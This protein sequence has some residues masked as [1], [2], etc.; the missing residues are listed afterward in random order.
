VNLLA[1]LAPVVAFLA[2]LLLMDSFKLVSVRSV[3]VAI[4]AGAVAALA[5]LVID[6]LALDR[7][8]LS[9]TVVSRYVA[10]VLEESAKAAFVMLLARRTRVGFL[11]DAAI[12]GFAVGTGFGL[13]ENVDY[14]RELQDDRLL[15]WLVRGFGTAML[16]GATTAIFAILLKR[17]TDRGPER[18]IAAA[19]PGWTAAVAIHSAYNHFLLPPLVATLLLLVLLPALVQV[20]FARSEKATHEWVGAGLDLD[21]ELLNLMLSP[22]F[23]ATRLGRYL[24]EL[25]EH[26][27]GPVVADMFCLL[28][29]EIE[30]GIRAKGMLM[31]REAG[32]EAPVDEALVAQLDEVAYLRRSI[33][34][35]GLI[36]LRPL[37]M[38]GARDEWHRYLLKQA[39]ATRSRLKA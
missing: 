20:V 18:G 9:L 13:V 28:R 3:G 10:P 27:P 7:L 35:T 15:L 30:L 21:V 26:F 11:V 14:L 8:N 6:G 16:H 34:R 32:L 24:K 23:T 12:V 38:T 2:V 39:A 36:A 19:L 17:E 1:A 37:Q 33:G 5:C 4:G 29:L 22:H 25:K 31:A